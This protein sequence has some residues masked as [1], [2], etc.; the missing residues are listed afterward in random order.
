MSPSFHTQPLQLFNSNA[1]FF[2]LTDGQDTKILHFKL[3]SI[4]VLL[5]W[6]IQKINN[7]MK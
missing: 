3:W 2:F 5:L 6:I 1:T 4:F 7:M